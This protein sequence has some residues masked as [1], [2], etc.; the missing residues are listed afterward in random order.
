VK[1]DLAPAPELVP[2]GFFALRTPLLPFAELE[3]FSAGLEAAEVAA[4]AAMPAI[5]DD[6]GELAEALARD[7]AVLRQRLRQ[8][9]ARPE[10]AEA[11]FLASPSL[12]DGLAAWHA[13]PDS[14]KGRR[15]ECAL[16]RYFLRMTA[17][18]TP[19]GLF[20]GCSTGRLGAATRLQL[21]PRGAYQR[22]TRLDMDYLF[23]LAEELGRDPALRRELLY[24]PNS[25]LYRAAG[26]WRYAEARLDGRIRS[27][28]LVALE[29][30]DY[31]DATLERARGGARAE[32]LAAA[33][34]A[35][36]PEVSAEEAAEFVGELIDCQVLV[37][38]LSPPVSGPEAI[39]DL[40]DQLAATEASRTAA[41]ALDEA[42]RTLDEIDAAGL[43]A[44]PDRYRDLAKRLEEQPALP[45]KVELSRL[46]QVDMV[47][48]GAALE[49]GEE[50]LAEL[51]R[52][53]DLLYRVAGRP[54]Q[55]P[56]DR[57]RQDFS[58]RYGDG[59][60]VPLFEALDEE[61]GIGFQRSDAASAEASPLLRGLALGQPQAE[62][63]APVTAAQ[64]F[65]TRKLEEA[66]A[67]GALE[68]AL[69]PA[70]FERM[71]EG[72]GEP[73]PLP[74]AFH[75]MGTLAAASEEDLA[76][77]RFRLLFR[78]AGGPS[79]ARLLGRFCHADRELEAQ[80]AAHLAAEEEWR[81]D[82]VFA[83]IVHLPQ[84]RIGNIL[85]RPLLR[86][87]EIPFLG[88]SGAPPEHRIPVSDLSVTVAGSRIVLRSERLGREIVPRLTSA[89]N[90]VTGSL[91]IY[92]FLCALQSQ[93][94][95]GGVGW[96]WGALDTASFLPRVSIGRLVLA[97]ARWR[98]GEEEIKAL[99]KKEGAARFAALARW[100][101][102][103]RLPRWVTLAD[104]DNELVVDLDNAL[105]VDTW[106]DLLEQRKE[107]LLHELFPGPEE[108]CAR[109]PEGAF[110]HEIVVPF[111]RA[112]PSESQPE[113]A[114]RPAAR[115]VRV[116]ARSEALSATAAMP[117]RVRRS[118]P[119]GSEWLYAK[120]YTGSSTADSLLRELV[121][122]VARAALAAGTAD[123]WFFIRYG[124]PHWHLRLRFHGEPGRLHGE[125]L[126]ALQ[127]AAGARLDDGRLW[128]FQ[129]DTYER[130]TERYGGP[131]AIALAERLF[132]VDS[133]AVLAIVEMLEGDEG[134]DARWR[135]ALLG[136][137]LLLADLGLGAA[138]KL[139]LLGGLRDSFQREF[140]GGAVP[141]KGLRV[142]LDQ[143]FRAERPGL[144]SLLDLG[145]DPDPA[146][147]ADNP[148]APGIEVLARRSRANA[149][150][151][152]ELRRLAGEGR[153]TAPVPEIA[154][155][156]VHMHVN[157][158]IRSAAR[159]HEL[160]LYDL[161]A[162]IYESRSARARSGAPMAGGTL[163]RS[164]RSQAGS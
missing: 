122:P 96:S 79:G 108:L 8:A 159:A 5:T 60:W 66:L 120:L 100:R 130:E 34:V 44:A 161:L 150:L 132:H 64:R 1:R 76:A 147:I 63:G 121:A 25:S 39:H 105:A 163:T 42:R 114:V 78:G 51:R 131:A 18:P 47:K 110:V 29:A 70:D 99:V 86:T 13:D 128:R 49:L 11:V 138:E 56:F 158:M 101:R 38:E 67:A 92:R 3:A 149:P 133:E 2:S 35:A 139:A 59:R 142:Q 89:H 14:K 117:V 102:E 33:L 9:I 111:V 146:K 24:R 36:D 65:L 93:G 141:A 50:P 94:Q 12:A 31:L 53:V 19:F 119:P 164:T 69:T 22:H 81:P 55:D 82:A 80:V 152:A 85:A 148:L 140:G 30:T 52:G 45:A 162:R 73:P 157:R 4:R 91:G 61:V 16:A 136:T 95:T 124:D 153:L 84:G 54:R 90:F 71:A 27:H 7:R 104:G 125:V 28:H 77:G 41:E 126:P 10:I 106:L 48:P 129:L 118:F 112:R 160:V 74:D 116:P 144:E 145:I 103:R 46:F 17:R 23:A 97:R 37:P 156:L 107:A 57:F 137:D 123:G 115:P 40:V 113:S 155:S 21:A 75:V 98:M 154:G 134:A 58:D 32:E 88:R 151:A 62:A 143:K 26:R 6:P 20:S 83:E 135:L 68:I 87:H 127:E 109:G 72:A 15:A 43:G